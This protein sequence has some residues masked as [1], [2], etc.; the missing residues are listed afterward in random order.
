MIN[1][2]LQDLHGLEEISV[3]TWNP[4]TGHALL[5]TRLFD[6]RAEILQGLRFA[7][8]CFSLTSSGTTHVGK[9]MN[10][11]EPFRWKEAD[12]YCAESALFFFFFAYIRRGVGW[13]WAD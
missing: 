1:K 5:L 13:A 3:F 10:W 9:G 7:G 11:I 12:A 2:S 8:T 6:R 4:H